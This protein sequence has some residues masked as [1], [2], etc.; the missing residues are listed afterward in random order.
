M[1]VSKQL[2]QPQ[3]LRKTEVVQVVPGLPGG[4]RCLLWSWLEG[5][6]TVSSAD[7]SHL[8]SAWSGPP[9][10]S[11]TCLHSAAAH[12]ARLHEAQPQ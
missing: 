11:L 9:H 4:P 10:G 2:T 1:K 3:R 8:L 6:V 7:L 5:E 12:S